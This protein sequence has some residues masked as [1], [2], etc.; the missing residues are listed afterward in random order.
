M[1]RL[2]GRVVF[3]GFLFV[4]VLMKLVFVIM[5]ISDVCVMFCRV[6]SLLVVRIVLM[7]VLL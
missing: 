3:I 7:W 5:Y 2:I 1:V 4:D 6:I